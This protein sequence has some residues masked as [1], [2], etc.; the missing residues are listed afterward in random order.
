MGYSV[1]EIMNPQT[2]LPAERAAETPETVADAVRPETVTRPETG[3]GAADGAVSSN[4]VAM[5]YANALQRGDTERAV[6]MTRWMRER[7]AYVQSQSGSPDAAEQ[8]RASLIEQLNDRG[9]EGNRLAEEGIEDQYVFAPG[10]LLEAVAVDAGRDDLAEPA[11]S[12]TWIRAVFPSR[13][14]APRDG[15]DVPVRAITAGVNVSKDGSILKANVIGN[16]ELDL[17]S[18]SYDW[19]SA[20]GE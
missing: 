16:L 12:R 19:A 18:I 4:T 17:D 2:R 6:A 5:Q 13:R 15:E 1:R 20:G 3:S 9:I 8:A 10:V 7:I 11:G 14:T